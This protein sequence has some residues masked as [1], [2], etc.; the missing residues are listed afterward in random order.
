[1]LLLAS[2]AFAGS[3]ATSFATDAGEW[4]GGALGDGVLEV[5]PAGASLNI[6]GMT[7][8]TLTLRVRVVD[9]STL[10]LTTGEQNFT[11]TYGEGGRLS[12]AEQTAPFAVDERSFD[13]VAYVNGAWLMAFTQVA[14]D[15]SSS[16]G[17]ATSADLQTWTAGPTLLTDAS[18]PSFALSTTTTLIAARDGSL[19]RAD[20]TD[21]V[22]F[23]ETGTILSPGPDFD[24]GGLDLPSVVIDSTGAWRL[25]YAAP[26]SGATGYATSGDGTSF[27]REGELSEDSSRL[28]AADVAETEFGFESVYSMTDSL[29]WATGGSDPSFSAEASDLR[30]LVSYNDASWADGGLG[31]PSLVVDGDDVYV[32]V[33]A[34]D[35]GQRAIGRFDGV[36]ES[37]NWASLVVSWDGETATVSWNGG[38]PMSGALT[39][40]DGFTLSTDGLVEIDEANLEYTDASSADSGD[41]GTIDTGDTAVDTAATDSG[42]TGVSSYD[43]AEDTAVGYNAGEWLG[44]PGGCGCNGAPV[45][46]GAMLSVTAGMTLLT[47]GRRGK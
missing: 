45:P 41:T 30:P 40:L 27:I 35:D 10:S 33:D 46:V 2:L 12:Y 4:V 24:A 44:D 14:S 38:P 23:S 5:D 42:D 31:S 17:S 39:G 11:A 29:G 6:E 16:I 13:E 18:A 34:S 26:E 25:W 47:R 15:G 36:P 21:G 19:V 32:F 37:G 20:S 3:S 8:F 7:S 43:T 9:G 28:W 22:T 1:M